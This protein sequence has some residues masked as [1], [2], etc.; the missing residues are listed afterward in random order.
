MM[1]SSLYLY[2]SPFL[3]LS[4]FYLSSISLSLSFSF[5]FILILGKIKLLCKGADQ[6]IFERLA[7]DQDD[8]KD[9]V[10]SELSNVRP[11]YLF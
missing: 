6:V 3:S 5:L 4:L 1:V 7:S 8:V 2:L 11:I 9:A 10:Y